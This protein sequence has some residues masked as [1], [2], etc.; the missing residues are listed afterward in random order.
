[1]GQDQASVLLLSVENFA[2]GRSSTFLVAYEKRNVM[3]LDYYRGLSLLLTFK[4][5]KKLTR[6]SERRY[7]ICP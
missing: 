6:Q 3:E 7:G 5:W 2:S 4:Y 1:M